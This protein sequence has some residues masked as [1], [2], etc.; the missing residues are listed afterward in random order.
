MLQQRECADPDQEVVE[1]N[2]RC[3]R[4]AEGARL[5]LQSRG[6]DVPLQAIVGNR[7][8]G[9]EQPARDDGARR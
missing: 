7:L 4:G 5:S 6:V 2:A 9:L 8:F 1:C 3:M